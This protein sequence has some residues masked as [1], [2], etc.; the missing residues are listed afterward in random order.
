LVTKALAELGAEVI[1]IESRSHPD[2]LR[3][4][5]PFRPGTSGLEASGYFASRNPNKKSFALNMGKPEAREIV[6]ELISKV[7]AVTSNFRPGIMEKWGLSY[8]EVQAINPEIIYMVMP[9]QG[10][11]GP[12]RSFIGFGSTIAAL[13]GLV[14]LSGEPGRIPV[15]TGTHYPDHVPNPGHSLLA[16]LTAILQRAQTGRGQKVEV[17]QFESTINVIGP[18]ILAASAGHE[19]M[20]TGNRAPGIVPRGV[21]RTSDS[22]WIV[23]SCA[24]DAQ[25]SS[26]AN[27]MIVDGV[28]L[29]ATYGTVA[30]RQGRTDELDSM[31]AGW[32]AKLERTDALRRLAE[33]MVPS[34]PVNTSADMLADTNL[35][36]RGFWQVVD[37]PVIGEMPMFTVPFIRDGVRQKMTPP[38]LLGEHTWEV[39]SALLDMSRDRYDELVEAE[40]LY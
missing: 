40:V 7:D 15:G 25:W 38:P 8:E 24:S 29:G 23:I 21:Y 1:R 5:P 35:N 13:G 3:L 16:V 28:D 6:S 14:Q 26:L 11:D 18:A 27:E 33:A 12:H 9:M 2:N 10:S 22:Q 36:E 19:P 39:A 32:V 31:V 20:A 4:A 37:H 34:G 17:S 30:E